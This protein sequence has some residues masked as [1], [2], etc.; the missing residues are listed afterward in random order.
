MDKKWIQENFDKGKQEVLKFARNSKIKIEITSL[1][2]KKDER[3]RLLGKKVLQMIENGELDSNPFEPD[4]TYIN[5]INQEIEEKEELLIINEQEN[6]ETEEPK[7]ESDDMDIVKIESQ[8]V[9]TADSIPVQP[10]EEKS[11]EE[12]EDKKNKEPKKDYNI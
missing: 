3:I 1:N 11:Q 12:E 7:N 9:L 10:D 4:Y 5:D 6:E 2:K 8:K